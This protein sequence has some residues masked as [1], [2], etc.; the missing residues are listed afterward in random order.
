MPIKHKNAPAPSFEVLKT[1]LTGAIPDPND[2]SLHIPHKVYQ[3]D[4]DGLLAGKRFAAAQLV[5]WRYVFRGVDQQPHVAEISVDEATDTHA[6]HHINQGSHVNNFIAL[7]DR[8]HAHETVAEKDY[9]INLLRAPACY[10]LAVWFKGVDHKHE[11][12]VPLS[13][14]HSN[15][16]ANKHYEAYE[17]MDLL[18]RT[19]SGM[20]G[21]I[22]APHEDDLT[23]IEGIGPKTAA[24]LREAGIVS[25][26]GVANISLPQLQKIL[27]TGGARFNLIDP[28]TWQEQAALAAAGKWDELQ[29]LQAILK[30]GSKG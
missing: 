27:A 25:F 18:E 7:Y 23:R 15:F 17:F 30:G 24:L 20:A 19:A 12:F 10:V 1:H 21:S 26:T 5:A 11:F 22:P 29:Q 28:T 8:I 6:F 9:E 14:V 13:P 16:E 2:H 4:N 3:V